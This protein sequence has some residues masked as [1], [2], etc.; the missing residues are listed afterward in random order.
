MPS[1]LV[2]GAN[3]GLGLELVRQQAEAGWQVH[4][5]CR[6]PGKATKLLEIAARHPGNVA[7]RTL[8]VAEGASIKALA[9]ELKSEPLDVLLNNAGTYGFKTFADKDGM[10]A[11]AFGTMNY[12]SWQYA[13][14]INTMAPLR[15]IE[16]LV[17]SVAVSDQ[18]KIFVMSSSLG[19]IEQ[20]QGGHL[21]Y[22]SSKAAVNFVVRSLAL[23]LKE[24]GITVMCLHPGW[25][26]TDMGGRQAPVDP[27]D[28]VSGLINVIA[29]ASLATTGTWVAYDGTTI[30][31]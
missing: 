30:P 19:S 10:P 26:R 21:A 4:A 1:I 15:M 17:D 6:D 13:L 9:R 25:A 14:S 7:V 11:Q 29:H 31:W 23:E 12:A 27:R 28:S 22:G 20:A 24:R 5:C 8:A 3:R 18:K 16:A 2:T